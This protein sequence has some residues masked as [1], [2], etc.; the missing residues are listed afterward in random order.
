MSTNTL[1]SVYHIIV[2]IIRMG[3]TVAICGE[4]M[5]DRLVQFVLASSGYRFPS[6]F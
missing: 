1:G 4:Q 5:D 6:G 3:S 2:V